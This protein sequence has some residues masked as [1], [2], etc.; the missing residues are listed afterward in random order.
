[1]V[2]MMGEMPDEDMP[3]RFEITLNAEVNLS[4]FN[5]P[6]RVTAPEDA[7]VINPAMFMGAGSS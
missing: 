7:E 3:E 6:V 1:M 4:G 2:A 5:E